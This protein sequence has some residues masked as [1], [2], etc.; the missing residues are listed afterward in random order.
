MPNGADPVRSM[1]I[2]IKKTLNTGIP[3]GR[4]RDQKK[5]VLII[6]ANKSSVEPGIG[7]GEER[8]M[9]VKKAKRVGNIYS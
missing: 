1:N 3:D 9:M 4:H 2:P 8:K 5:T 7:N 6:I